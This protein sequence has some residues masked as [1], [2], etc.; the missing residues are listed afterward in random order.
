[1]CS[2]V[3]FIYIQIID[4]VQWNF[5]SVAGIFV[6]G[7]VNNMN[8]CIPGNVVTLHC[9]VLI[10]GTYINVVVSYLQELICILLLANILQ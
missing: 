8:I 2:N 9:S 6:Q 4:V 1:M 7:H 3:G 5:C 10:W